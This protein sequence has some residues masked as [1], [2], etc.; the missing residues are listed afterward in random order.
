[1]Q[2]ARRWRWRVDSGDLQARLT[3]EGERSTKPKGFPHERGITRRSGRTRTFDAQANEDFT[4]LTGTSSAAC[5]GQP[6]TH[7]PVLPYCKKRD[8]AHGKAQRC[9]RA[10]CLGALRPAIATDDRKLRNHHLREQFLES[11]GV[12]RSPP[13]PLVPAV[14]G[15]TL[16]STRRLTVRR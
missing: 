7:R 2:W 8:S 6:T 15:D 11:L 9:F 13:C 14:T 4:L 5:L 1:M 12:R 3:I 16:H 10:T